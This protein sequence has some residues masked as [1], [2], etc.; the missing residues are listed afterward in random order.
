[1]IKDTAEKGNVYYKWEISF[2]SHTNHIYIR[3]NIF[4]GSLI[5]QIS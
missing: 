5:L 2:I 1:M 4:T 3:A